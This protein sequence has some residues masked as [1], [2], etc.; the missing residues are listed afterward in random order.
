MQFAYNIERLWYLCS[1]RNS[2]LVRKMMEEVE[3]ERKVE[4]PDSILEEVS[5]V[6]YHILTAEDWPCARD[7]G[8]H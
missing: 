7:H 6:L 3:M 8:D 4:T 5:I 2:E 1:E